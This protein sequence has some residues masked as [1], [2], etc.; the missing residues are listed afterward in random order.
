MD[1]GDS[2]I[3]TVLCWLACA[4]E[5]CCAAVNIGTNSER[6]N[7]TKCCDWN[8]HNN[9]YMKLF[10]ISLAYNMNCQE[11]DGAMAPAGAPTPTGAARAWLWQRKDPCGSYGALPMWKPSS[12]SARDTCQA[13]RQLMSLRHLAP[14]H[15]ATE[16]TPIRQMSWPTGVFI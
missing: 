13:P 4:L 6:G 11:H 12:F 5:P 15:V 10:Q 14:E 9:C 7:D 2:V 1:N 3:F 16:T 8:A